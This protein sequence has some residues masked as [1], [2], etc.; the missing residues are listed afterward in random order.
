MGLS[1]DERGWIM[2]VI[3]GIACTV[4]AS[5]ICV[6]VIIRRLP[7]Q[8]NFKIEN[9]NAFMSSGLSLSFGVMIFTSLYSMLPEA[10]EYFQK[11]GLTKRS[12]IFA[13]VGLMAAGA[14]GIAVVSRIVH[15]YIPHQVVDCDHGHEEGDEEE[16]KDSAKPGDFDSPN[17]ALPDGLQGIADDPDGGHHPH[18]S[19]QNSHH[20]S[21]L[22]RRPSLHTQIST[23]VSQLVTGTQELCDEN[24]QC[25][26]FSDPCGLDCFRNIRLSRNPRTA[27]GKL[28]TRPAGARTQ[29]TPHER[30]PLLQDVDESSPLVPSVS[31]PATM[32]SSV[33]SLNGHANHD[34]Q[35][36][37][38]T[39][40]LSH[41]HNAPSYTS[42]SPSSSSSSLKHSHSHSS[43]HAHAHAH[44]HSN[45]TAKPQSQH[46]HHVPQNIFL[47]IGL[48][49]SIA[50]A[51]HKI[52]EGFITYA[53]N[54][55]NPSL[56]VPIFLSLFIHNITE[57]F[58]M[59]LP[60]YL[61]IRSRWR[62]M[63]VS[64]VLGGISQP[65]GAAVA[66]LS[67]KLADGRVSDGAS[68][69]KLYGCMFAGTAGIMA[70]V[71]LQLFGESLDL[72]HSRPLC[73][74]SAI[75]GMCILGLSSG[76]TAV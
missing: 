34:L 71:G 30:Q 19:L 12:A 58:A 62:A 33:A 73:F 13:S 63:L 35:P 43:P 69:D 72:T 24:G 46:H 5:I 70:M 28:S 31:G 75:L 64:T 21:R 55:A 42:S 74:A 45:H 60:L 7:R 48:Q 23:K 16:G 67:F 40:S 8:K 18:G 10:R 4:G 11:G 59:A 17:G 2:T 50:I 29:T 37:T 1:N 38:S 36:K 51:L 3:S 25:K 41:H 44:A 66:A 14:L 52:P 68:M 57:G 26:G 39:H 65:L 27:T 56:G 22:T 6:D 15:R 76:L 32:E 53:T 20:H 54:H 47:S 61:A 9:S 49:T